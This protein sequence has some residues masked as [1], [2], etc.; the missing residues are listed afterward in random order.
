MSLGPCFTNSTPPPAFLAFILTT[1][2]YVLVTSLP[3]ISVLLFFFFPPSLFVAYSPRDT[4][5]GSVSLFN[6][7][8]LRGMDSWLIPFN[9]SI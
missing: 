7:F 5:D 2:P 1:E 6:E 9:F 4:V 8:I 3:Q